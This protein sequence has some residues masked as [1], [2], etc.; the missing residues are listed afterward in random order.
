MKKLYENIEDINIKGGVGQ[1]SE[2][3]TAMDVSLQKIADNTDKLTGILNKYSVANKGTQYERVVNTSMELRDV[4]FSASLELNEMQN[5]IVAYQNKVYRYEDLNEIAAQPNPYLVEKH[6]VSVE[7]SSVQFVKADMM[8][9]SA[10]LKNY[11]QSV[12]YHLKSIKDIKDTIA[13]VWRDTQYRDFAEFIEEVTKTVVV[14][15]NK[16]EEYY[17]YLEDRIKELS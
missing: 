7:T 11:S 10:A 6:H 1:L 12:M 2:V 5:Q 9:V 3:V 8:N 17:R 15:V 4:L 16:F 13:S 14:A